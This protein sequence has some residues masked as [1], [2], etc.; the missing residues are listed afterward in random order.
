MLA[1][2]A[3]PKSGYLTVSFTRPG[4]IREY[5]YVHDLVA[6]TFIG[7]CASGLEVCH[8][9]GNRKDC[10]ETNLRYGT[11]SSNALDRHEHGTMNQAF[12]EAHYHHKLTDADVLWIRANASGMSQREMGRTLDVCHKTI[13]SV[14]KGES[15]KHVA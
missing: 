2:V 15:W 13:G 9:N 1:L 6:E 3:N 5:R 11:R 4:G 10:R 8:K 14:L 7:P 12:G